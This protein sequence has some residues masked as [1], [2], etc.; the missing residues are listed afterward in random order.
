MS[1]VKKLMMAG[2]TF[3]VALGIGFA[4]Q[5]GDA[6]AA[7]FAADA[8]VVSEIAPP[9]AEPMAVVAA[10]FADDPT[11]DPAMSAPMTESLSAAIAIP[12]PM[13]KPTTPAEPI[14]LAAVE[15]DAPMTDAMKPDAALPPADCRAEMTAV[16]APAAMVTLDLSAP[17][18]ASATFVIHHQGM[19]ISA[20]T[21][22]DGFASVTVPALA[23]EAVFIAAFD[24]GQG[25]V[26]AIAA[27]DVDNF[28]RAVL[29]WQ[30]D[31]GVNIQAY[32]NGAIFGAPGNVSVASPRDAS[33]AVAGDGGF[34]VRL[35]ATGAVNPL[36]AEIYTYPVGV[37][38]RD[39]SVDL[40]VEA[41]ITSVNCGRDI[42]AQSIQVVPGQDPRAT[43]LTLTMP[44]CD[45]VGDFLVLN[46]MFEDIR[47]AAR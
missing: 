41:E 32:E 44:A 8:A 18:N 9:L 31:A 28:E 29:L 22:A 12:A 25:A 30:G 42:A 20:L 5:N 19:M 37:T 39:G 43:D 17:C 26:A 4:M 34:L 23:K 21:D 33:V 14:R 40:N 11:S 47:V 10:A 2:G 24:N 1:Q 7:R 38:A 15:A 46:N 3:S 27:P 16:T 45:G 36:M 35:G 13:L 6:L